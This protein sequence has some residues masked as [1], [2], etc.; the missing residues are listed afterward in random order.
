MEAANRIWAY[1]DR[2]GFGRFTVERDLENVDG[3]YRDS[4]IPYIRSDLVEKLIERVEHGSQC[5][6]WDFDPRTWRS[7]Y[8]TCGLDDL[9]REVRG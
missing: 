9:I 2:D 7:E 5:E 4:V 8:C 1:E 6:Y 3:R